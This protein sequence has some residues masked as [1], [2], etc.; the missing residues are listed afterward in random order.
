MKRAI[1]RKGDDEELE[2]LDV[3]PREILMQYLENSFPVH[4]YESFVDEDG[5][6]GTRIVLD[7]A[8]NPVVDQEAAR[9]RDEL[10]DGVGAFKIPE[11]PLDMIINHFGHEQV[12]EATGRTQR[13]IEKEND[14]G[15]RKKM[16]ERRQPATA[17]AVE[18]RAFQDGKKKILVF[19][20][21]GGTGRSYHAN[22]NDPNQNKRVHYLLQAGWRADKAIQGLGR[23]H[24]TNQASAPTYRLVEIDAVR[25]QRRF[26]TT[27]ARRLDQLG[28]LTRGQRQAG[29]AGLFKAADNLESN[30]AVEALDQFFGDLSSARIEDLNQKEVMTQLGYFNEREEERRR[31]EGKEAKKFE[32]PPMSQFLNRL[33]SLNVDMQAKVFD[34]FDDR[35]QKKVEQVVREGT[36]DVGVENY[37]ATH[38]AAKS[39]NVVYREPSTGAEA[40][41]VVVNAKVNTERKT[42][43]EANARQKPLYYVRNTETG[44]VRAV[45][46]WTDRTDATT[47][48]VESQVKVQGPGG[49]KFMTPYAANPEAYGSKYERITETEAARLWQEEF[50]ELP[51]H[52]ETEQ[53]FVAGAFLPIWD[54][55]PGDKPKIYRLHLEDGRTIVARHIPPKKVAETL[56]KL[57]IDHQKQAAS[58]DDLHERLKTGQIRAE[59]VNG[60]KLKPARVQGEPRIELIGPSGYHFA[61]LEKDGVMRER[62][63]YDTRFF[64][65]TG[66]AGAKVIARIIKERPVSEE[67]EIESGRSAGPQ[68]RNLSLAVPSGVSIAT[69]REV[70]PIPPH[71][72][73]A[74]NRLREAWAIVSR[75]W[76]SMAA[77][78]TRFEE[79]PGPALASI[80][81]KTGVLSIRA[82]SILDPVVLWH[83]LVHVEQADAGDD[84]PTP[85]REREA[86][87]RAREA[88]RLIAE[89]TAADEVDY[90]ADQLTSTGTGGMSISLNG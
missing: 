17:N 44:R 14:E 1:A 70:L 51:M 39:E 74:E 3:S 66:E 5:N 8:G 73:V 42:L 19:S 6:E 7:S 37:P 16:R 58:A 46:S 4:R 23:T 45:Y 10:L 34:A 26:I 18:A 50:D 13:V 60:W 62:I 25:A 63:Q 72:G 11:S 15:E 90:D 36:L 48:R 43:A 20:D 52:R 24:R 2:D 9:M 65:P 22:R 81:P 21:A 71:P 88:R 59:L 41:H 33:L 57:G 12:A 31:Q 38:I 64:I 32:T 55:L 68:R 47:G 82:G 53:H 69:K 85:Q 86:S 61:E 29:S 77:K 27:I 35:L 76:P 30:E 28:A 84:R 40:K 67:T 56:R 87:R 89:F 80:N 75:I 78:V 54:R 79:G 49:A 83:E